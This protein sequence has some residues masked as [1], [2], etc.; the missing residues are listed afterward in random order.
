M[1]NRT[2]EIVH[3]NSSLV[4]LWKIFYENKFLAKQWHC[5]FKF[6]PF[7]TGATYYYNWFF[8]AKPL[9]QLAI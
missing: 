6:N 1:R 4:F 7:I 3:V 5:S 2:T 9:C 8:G